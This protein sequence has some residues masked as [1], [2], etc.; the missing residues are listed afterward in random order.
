M[1]EP[2]HSLAYFSRSAIRHDPGVLE[3]DI[4]QILATARR[5]NSS[6]GV[7][8]ALLF[9]E[10]CFTQVL[11]GPLGEVEALF[12]MIECDPRHHD[13]TILHLHE[14]ETRSF[15]RWSMAFAG[16]DATMRQRAL[17]AAALD[18][19]ADIQAG[20]AGQNFLAVLQDLVQRDEA[21]ARED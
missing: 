4:G 18:D 9:A 11:E 3:A 13:I 8:G 17:A 19:P 15:A 6:V 2:L 21:Y 5:R 12:E 10:G 20:R 7:T 16:Q 14:V 1:T